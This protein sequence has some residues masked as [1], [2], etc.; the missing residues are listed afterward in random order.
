LRYSAPA[1]ATYAED[2]DE[3]LRQ[4]LNALKAQV[5]SLQDIVSALKKQVGELQTR[6]ATLQA[7]LS[8]AKTVL[9]L[10]PFLSIDSNP[11]A[12]GTGTIITFH[13]ANVRFFGGSGPTND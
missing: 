11:E 13:G 3:G 1:P 5:A 6:D 10:E 7:Q 4:E 9:A 2:P 12:G 8:D